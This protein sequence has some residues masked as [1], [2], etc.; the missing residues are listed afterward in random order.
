MVCEFIVIIYCPQ[1]PLKKAFQIHEVTVEKVMGKLRRSK[2]TAESEQLI[3]SL[4]TALNYVSHM[5]A[6]QV[7]KHTVLLPNKFLLLCV[8]CV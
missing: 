7:S 1:P 2:S 4:V 6:L 3:G 8:A 5:R